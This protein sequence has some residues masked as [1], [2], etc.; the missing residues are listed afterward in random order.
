VTEISLWLDH[1]ELGQYAAPFVENA[2][3]DVIH[4]DFEG[5]PLRDRKRIVRVISSTTINSRRAT[6]GFSSTPYRS[7]AEGGQLTAVFCDLIG[8]T[9]LAVRLDPEE[10]SAVIHRYQMTSTGVVTS[11]GGCVG[12]FLGDGIFAY[13]GY[14]GPDPAGLGDV[15]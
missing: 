11:Y 1:F 13:F 9:A 3:D 6:V 8:S 15:P 7:E 4:A 5:V 12:Q 14:L 2:I 10:L